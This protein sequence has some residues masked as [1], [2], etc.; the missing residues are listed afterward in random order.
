MPLIPPAGRPA[1]QAGR[2]AGRPSGVGKLNILHSLPG[3]S[4][5]QRSDDLHPQAVPLL[6]SAG[7]RGLVGTQLVRQGGQHLLQH[8]GIMG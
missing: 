3:C 1:S 6:C 4:G 7:G 2:Q 8:L 5:R